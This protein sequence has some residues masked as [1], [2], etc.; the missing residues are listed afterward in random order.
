MSRAL[1]VL[2][3][4]VANSARSQMAEAL[5]RNSGGARYQAFSAGSQ[6]AQVDPRALAALEHAGI[7]SE[8]LHS[9]SVD[10]FAG[11]RFD[12]VITLC[13]KSALECAALPQ[14]VQDQ[15]GEALVTVDLAQGQVTVQTVLGEEAVRE[16]IREEGY[17]V[18]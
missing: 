4:C 10:S 7:P 3:L 14:A 12:Y 15:D 1:K 11:D 8:G 5:L 18:A 17:G 13:D 6:P 9:K 16:I 2:F